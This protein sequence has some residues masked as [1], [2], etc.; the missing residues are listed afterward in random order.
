[1]Q[2]RSIDILSILNLLTLLMNFNSFNIKIL[3]YP[4]STTYLNRKYKD[5]YVHMSQTVQE[6]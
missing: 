2:Q 4:M 3:I 6:S 5:F 1:M